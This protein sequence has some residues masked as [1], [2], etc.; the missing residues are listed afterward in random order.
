MKEKENLF[1]NDEIIEASE[2]LIGTMETLDSF[3]SQKIE[4]ATSLD[5]TDKQLRIYNEMVFTCPFCEW[6][7]E[8]GEQIETED[9]EEVCQS[10]FEDYMS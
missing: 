8:L 3:L 5:L 2:Y 6:N 7:Y 1:T 4:G 9:G 10:C